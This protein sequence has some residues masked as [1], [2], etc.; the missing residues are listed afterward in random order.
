[1]VR[2]SAAE[3]AVAPVIVTALLPTEVTTPLMAIV[4]VWVAT[5][6]VAATAIGTVI[7]QLPLVGITPPAMV[8]CVAPL[9]AVMLPP[10][11]VVDGVA[12][13][14]YGA[15]VKP[16]P[17]VVRLSVTL[18]MV[19]ADAVR[20]VRVTVIAITPV[21]TRLPLKA[22]LPEILLA[23]FTVSVALPAL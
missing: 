21:C 9:V 5:V 20:L 13:G 14:G 17:I 10:A 16:V 3:M 15:I 18:V 11:Q 4:L 2:V 22:L 8:N 23:G 12:A 1:M 19:A 6:A 7:V